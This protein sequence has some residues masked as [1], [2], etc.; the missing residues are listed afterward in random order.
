MISHIN[1]ARIRSVLERPDVTDLMKTASDQGEPALK[2]VQDTL[3]AEFSANIKNNNSLKQMI[4]RIAKKIMA[5]EGYKH[6]EY[7]V[8]INGPVFTVAS[9]YEKKI[10]P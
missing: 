9:R 1:S 8:P 2:P 5:S 4:G 10:Y 6:C 7:N 3:I